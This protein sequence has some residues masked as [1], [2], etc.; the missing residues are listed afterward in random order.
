[1]LLACFEAL[2]TARL[3]RQLP[4]S[5]R[6][7]PGLLSAA[8]GPE[9]HRSVASLVESQSMRSES[10]GS[11]VTYLAGAVVGAQSVGPSCGAA[12][13]ALLGSRSRI[14]LGASRFLL[15]ASGGGVEVF[16]GGGDLGVA[17]AVHNGFEVGAVELTRFRGHLVSAVMVMPQGFL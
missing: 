5:M 4:L 2:P 1:V 17:H 13:W 8:Y 10:S 6:S 11:V 3:G 16:L 14:R 15:S 12:P 7:E 9:E